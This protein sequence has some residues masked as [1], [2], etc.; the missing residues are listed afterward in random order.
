MRQL[1]DAAVAIHP[2]LKM[3]CMLGA[4]SAQPNLEREGEG[5]NETR[6]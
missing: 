2:S 1:Q 6:R 5:I 3:P 4:T